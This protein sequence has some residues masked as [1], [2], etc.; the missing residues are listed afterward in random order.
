[1]NKITRQTHKIDATDQSVGRLAS[2]I[3]ILLRGKN[4]P[5]FEPHIDNGDLVY[6]AN[7]NKVKFTGKKIDQKKYYN[8]SSYPGGLRETKLKDLFKKDPMEVLRKAVK[9]M[10]PPTKL[11]EGM[12]QRLII[13]KLEK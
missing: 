6:V 2:R 11:R 10:L 9:Q 1:M 12:L 13:G 8:H 5:D 7:V 3:A 4:K